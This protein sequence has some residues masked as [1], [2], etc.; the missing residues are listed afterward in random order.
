MMRRLFV[1]LMAFG[2]AVSCRF[3]SPELST[4][5]GYTEE[6]SQ[7]YLLNP[8][9]VFLSEEG[10]HEASWQKD[11][12]EFVLSGVD[13]WNC[14][15]SQGPD[16]DAHVNLSITKDAGD[17]VF[18]SSGTI[19]ES[20]GY[21]TGIDGTVRSDGQ[22]WEGLF[23]IEVSLNGQKLDWGEARFEGAISP[24]YQSGQFNTH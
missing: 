23:R 4:M 24:V 19:V 22:R 13:T 1:L 11:G 21:K 16:P 9:S 17:H 5:E 6:L 8:A 14:S 20:S 12:F 15:I 10:K 2:V 18:V 7:R 3:H